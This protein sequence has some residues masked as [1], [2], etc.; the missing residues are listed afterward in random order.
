MNWQ[1]F[2]LGCFGV[3]LVLSL[4]SFLSGA[5][6]LHLPVKCISTSKGGILAPCIQGRQRV[7]EFTTA[8]RIFRFSIPH[9]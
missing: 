1:A 9:P 8:R 5:L 2:Y 6:H 7:T 3:G 4:V